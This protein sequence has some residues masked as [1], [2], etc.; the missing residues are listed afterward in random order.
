MCGFAGIYNRH[1]KPVDTAVLAR[2]GA[3]MRHRG[4]DDRG[5]EA[6]GERRDVGFA[7]QR[8]SIID[9]S[10][11]G[12]Q[13]MWSD[14]RRLCMVYNG[15]VYNAMALRREL[16]AQG[17]R[18]RGDSDTEVILRL[19]EAQGVK[20]F[21]RLNGMFAIALWDGAAG[22]LHLVRD[23]IGIKPLYYARAGEAVVFAS[24]IKALFCHPGVKR[25]FDAVGVSDYM[26]YQFCL[27]EHTVFEGVK[28]LSPATVMTFDLHKP[29]A[30][31]VREVFWRFQYR[32]DYSRPLQDF[33][34]ELRLRLEGA[35][36]RQTRSDVPVGTFLSSGMDTGAISALA[37]RH[38]PGMHSFTCGFDTTGLSGEEVLYDER[39]DAQALADLLGTQHHT[40]TL[41][42]TAL[43]ELFRQTCWHMESPQVGISYQILAMA[44]VIKPYTTVVLSGTGGDELFA[45]YHWRYHGLLDE[46]NPKALDD[47]MYGRWCRLLD[48]ATRQSTLA[49]G[50]LAAGGRPR[51]R[52]DAVMAECESD[53][54]LPR[55][56]HFEL[57]GFLHGL[58]QL[59]DKLNM[60]YSIEARVPLL[61]NDV[62][63]LAQ[64][65]PAGMKYDGEN[66]K[67]VLKQALKGILP[68][69]VINRRKQGFTPPDAASMRG[70]NREWVEGILRSPRFAEMG[71]F[72]AQEV[73]R[74][75]AEHL[76]GAQNHRFLIWAL[77]CLHG[78]QE[79]YIED[80]THC[81]T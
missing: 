45:G 68:D 36:K 14:S 21:S 38:L 58:L 54:A 75:W 16:E 8:L 43:R 80:T 12:H 42:Q 25:S 5:C 46:K 29:K 24:E 71:L 65:I 49:P 39:K 44:E 18:F 19:Y 23:R 6:L 60:A 10:S 48:D 37:V 26:T 69:A 28:L 35:L 70:V 64:T 57:R 33:A 47:A 67:I 27:G 73:E 31:P 72:N 20:A 61:D 79:L 59:D 50:V 40:L 3:L 7:F 2:M 66:T 81:F 13:P 34:E 30:Q 77:L 63:E 74:L 56:L 17:V 32:P 22:M 9:L 4:P 55:L 52:F 51:E 62:L 53:E 78:A 41:G 76:S 15:E 11:A 1:G